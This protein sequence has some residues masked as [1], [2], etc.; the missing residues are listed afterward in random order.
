MIAA[1]ITPKHLTRSA[2]VYIRQ[3]TLSQVQENLESQRRQ[4]ELADQARSLGW[5]QVEVV[6]EDLGR[7]GSGRV[8]RPGF[9]RL[10]SAVCLE[11]VGGVFALEAS[12]LARNNRDWY[13]LIDLCG[14]TST[15]II[16]AEGV[17]DPHHLND[18]LL[19]GLKGTMSEW[20]LGVMRQRS[21]VALREKA[22]RGELYST[23]PIGF[24]R[25]RDDRCELEPDLRIQKS[26]G[27][28][29]EKFEEVGSIRQVLLW[30]RQEGVEL[31]GVRYGP[32]G[33]S[34][35]WKLPV[36]ST[37]H[38]IL[39]N[40]VYAG[41]YAYGRTRTETAIVDGQPRRRQ[42]IPVA[43]DEWAVLIPQHHEGYI[44]WDQYRAN[45][46]RIA[47]N[48]QMKRLAS[49]GAPRRGRSLLAGLLRCRR[50][51]RRLHVTYSGATGRVPRYGCR[52]A[53]VNH[54]AGSCISFGGLAADR[55]VEDAV[56]AVIQP[57]AIEAA[58]Q[59][60]EHAKADRERD[61]DVLALKLEQVR[62]EA[63]R[64]R[65]QYDATEPENRLVAAELE[66]RWNRALEVVAEVE[67][68]WVV[69]E[70]GERQKDETIDRVALLELAEDLPGVWH[71]PQCD[72][73]L[74]KR[75]V[76]TLIDEILVDVD[77][78]AARIHMVVRWAGG[79]HARLSVRKRRKGQHRYTTDRKVVEIVRELA[80]MLPDGQIARILNRLGLKTGRNNS[81]I[82]SRVTS[83]RNY[84]GIPVYDPVACKR[85]G[86]LT[87]EEA[88]ASMDVSPSVVRRLLRRGI[89]P[90]RQVVPYAPW[91]I[92]AADL[93]DPAVQEYVERV[94]AGRNVPRTPDPDQ[95][96]ID[97]ADT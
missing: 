31:P 73:R 84:H 30:F 61:R 89:L 94:H 87:L 21:L 17:Y 22:E 90:G 69:F 36:Y 71:D 18:R 9:Q 41:A 45:Q 8:V 3:S 13:Q 55:A 86:L 5:S 35:V 85:E 75:I 25:T 52:G 7:S 95:L 10:V 49:R 64:A 11:Q 59:A 28:V 12:R 20:E 97:P 39:T 14:L 34:V 83:L 88:A 19:L 51:G 72:M 15:L 24:L 38:K 65:R 82:A 92:Q 46:K 26:I 43:R 76:R 33:R 63:E 6:D 4:Y 79:Q 70:T 1:K 29:F 42:G 67:R 47:E 78:E 93:D 37:V 96:T 58:I 74:K 54:G 66:R 27:L 91:A 23:L 81:W 56:L 32:F 44:G 77:E 60:A 62:Y 40:P 48:A 16:D 68:E 80:A 53:A 57:G 50:C 2:Y